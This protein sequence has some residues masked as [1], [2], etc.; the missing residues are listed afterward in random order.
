M[1]I[2]SHS[3]LKRYKETQK[4]KPLERGFNLVKLYYNNQFQVS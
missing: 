4:K 1:Y 2:H 3:K